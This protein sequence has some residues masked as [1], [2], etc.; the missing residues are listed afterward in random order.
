MAPQLDFRAIFDP[1]KESLQWVL[2]RDQGSRGPGRGG[3]DPALGHRVEIHK[4]TLPLPAT[5]RPITDV[6]AEI[7]AAAATFACAAK[8]M[9]IS[10]IMK[11]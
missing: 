10:M 11:G 9:R 4:L 8:L 1:S 6:G 5:S 3:L 7:E 2:P